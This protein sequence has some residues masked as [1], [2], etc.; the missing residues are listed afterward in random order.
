MATNGAENT[1]QKNLVVDTADENTLKLKRIHSSSNFKY[2][3]IPTT[4][5]DD[6]VAEVETNK[7]DKERAG[8]ETTHDKH[9]PAEH[10]HHTKPCWLHT[11]VA[12]YP[13]PCCCFFLFWFI[14]CGI[15]IMATP[16]LL[17][18]SPDVPFYIRD[19]EATTL[20]DSVK[21]GENDA[22]WQRDSDANANTI[23]QESSAGVDLNLVFTALDGNTLMTERYLGMIFVSVF[24]LIMYSYI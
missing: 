16:G 22:T 5:R 17:A 8:N 11:L 19:N 24:V 20:S 2:N 7:E 15:I 23:S 10:I 1:D 6:S 4:D 14:L 21:A 3:Q 9:G 18:Y 13:L 12:K